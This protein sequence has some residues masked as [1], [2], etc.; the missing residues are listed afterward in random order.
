MNVTIDLKAFT[1]KISDREFDQLCA[2][3]PEAKFETTKEGKLIVMSP[4]GSQSGKFN[5]SLAFQVELWNRNAGNP[6]VV[7]DSSTG[8][9]LSNG[10]TRSPDVSWIELARWNSLTAKQQ[11]GFAPIDPDFVIELMSPTDELLELQ[12]KMEEYISCGVRFGWLINPDERQVEIYR[13]GQDKEVLLRPIS[14]SGEHCLPG[15]TVDLAEIFA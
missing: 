7:F 13:V 15:F 12:H 6:G 3:N 1:D 11:R 8:F 14:I 2:D 10:A 5:M 9:K 4:T